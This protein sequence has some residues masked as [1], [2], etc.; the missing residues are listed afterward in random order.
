MIATENT[1]DSSKLRVDPVARISLARSTISFRFSLVIA[2]SYNSRAMAG[3]K[4]PLFP[5]DIPT[6]PDLRLLDCPACKLD[7]TSAGWVLVVTFDGSVHDYK[8]VR[9]SSCEGG[10]KIT[11]DQFVIW[12]R[13]PRAD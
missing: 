9:C 12:Q 11:R 8:T 10:G 13:R 1:V 2:T 3:N 5:E 4:H 6:Q 7:G